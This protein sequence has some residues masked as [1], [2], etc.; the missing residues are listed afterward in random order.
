[1]ILRH[2]A[3]VL[4]VKVGVYIL[5]VGHRKLLNLCYVNSNWM[6]IEHGGNNAENQISVLLRTY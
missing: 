5:M 3:H 6:I 4:Y 1:M 2:V